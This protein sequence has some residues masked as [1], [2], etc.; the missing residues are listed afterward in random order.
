MKQYTGE[1][2]VYVPDYKGKFEACSI[3]SGAPQRGKL[4]PVSNAIVLTFDELIDLM[5]ESIEL[6]YPTLLRTEVT[7][8]LTA[9]GINIL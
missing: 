9:K 8:L 7:R 1:E 5:Q 6:S 2:K 3:K 4:T